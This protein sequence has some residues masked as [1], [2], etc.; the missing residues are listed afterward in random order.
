MADTELSFEYTVVDAD[1][2]SGPACCLDVC[3]LGDLD[4]DGRTDILVGSQYSVGLVWY[5]NPDW[6][7]YPIGPGEFTTDAQI[8][9]LDRDGRQE[10]WQ[11][12]VGP[13]GSGR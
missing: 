8:A 12:V 4:G 10:V 5:H 9:D 11:A 3:A 2:P 6:R 13:A 1:P 7:R